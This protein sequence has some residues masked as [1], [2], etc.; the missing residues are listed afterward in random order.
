MGGG[1][2]KQETNDGWLIPQEHF[3]GCSLENWLLAF[4]ERVIRLCNKNISAVAVCGLLVRSFLFFLSF[5]YFFH[6]ETISNERSTR[7][8]FNSISLES[9][10]AGR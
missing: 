4:V 2:G 3:V 10:Q 9:D 1:A 5:F 6:R 8:F 7:L